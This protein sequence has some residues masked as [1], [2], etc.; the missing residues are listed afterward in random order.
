MN[1]ISNVLNLLN[2]LNK[3]PIVPTPAS[4]PTEPALVP[5]VTLPTVSPVPTIQPSSKWDFVCLNTT[6]LTEQ[7]FIEAA[8]ILGVEVAV[9]KCVTEV[10]SKGGGYLPSR[11]PKILFE[12]HLF[13]K[14]T[15]SKYLQSHPNIASIKWDRTLYKGGEKEYPRLE[16]AMALDE[17]AAL[18]SASWGAFQILGSN[19]K[20]CGFATVEEF[21]KANIESEKKQLLAFISFVKSNKLDVHL[22]N[23]DWESFAKK[24]NGPGYLQNAYDTKLQDAYNKFK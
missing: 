9:I 8:S 1:F 22:K 5:T 10:E 20:A 17:K 6:K 16:E 11:K 3:K 2:S 4:Q 18:C 21:V 13:N 7:D 12:S 19:H 15:T 14:V 24:Y 23:K